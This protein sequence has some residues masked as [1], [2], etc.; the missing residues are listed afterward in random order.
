MYYV[1]IDIAKR[2]HVAVIMNED[3]SLEIKPFSFNNDKAGF[4]KLL[5]HLQTLCCDLSDIVIGMEATGLLFEN[6]YRHL[7][8]LEYNVVLLNPYQTAKFREMDTMKRVKNDNIDSVMIAALLKSGRFS[9][10]YVSQEQLQSLRELYRHRSS[11]E[12]QIKSLKRRTSAILTVVFPELETVIRDPFNVSGLALLD[13]YPTA[14]HFHHASVERILKTFRGIKGNNFNRVKAQALL[15]ASKRSIYSGIASDARALNI[16]M[17]IAQIRL[18]K[19]QLG[20]TLLVMQSLFS[21]HSEVKQEDREVMETLIDNLRTIP[22]VADKTILAL[23][24]ECGNLDRF[25]APK[26]LIGFL[27]LY[28]TLSQSGDS[29]RNGRLAKRGASLAKKA[30]YLASIAAIRHND[31]MRTIYMNYRSKG[32]AKKEA[33]II[34]ARKLLTIIYTIYTRNIPYDPQRVFVAKPNQ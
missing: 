28:P 23:L 9:E 12:D 1:G 27:G 11:I 10:G 2:T 31:E 30:I 20:E 17:N 3:N 21:N 19:E 25:Y 34:V 8:S 32:R 24:A 33:I 18:L 14:K 29:T 6:L 22:G 26:A 4:K 13:K 7:Q 15:D 16:R 5:I